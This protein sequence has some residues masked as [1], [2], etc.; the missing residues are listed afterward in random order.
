[1]K[2]AAFCIKRRVMIILAYIMVVIFGFVSFH[3]LALALMPNMEL[4][5][6]IVYTIYP[7]AG[8]EEVENLVTRPIEQ[9]LASLS[10]MDSLQSTSSENMSMVI[11]Q[12]TDDTDM[13]DAITNM[14]DKIDQM[15]TSLP[16]DCN[17]PT[18]IELDPDAMPVIQFG[19]T[20]SDLAQLQ[21]LG[22][23][24]ISPALERIDGVASV[25]IYGGYT[26]EIA[27]DMNT[28][29]MRGYNLSISYISQMLS[30]ENVAIPAG[31]IQNGTQKLTVRT[32]GEYANV[33]DIANTIIPLPTGGTIRLS[34]IAQVYQTHAD[35][36]SI[37]KMDGEQCVTMSVN[38]RSGVNTAAVAEEAI[39]V[40]AELKASNPQIEY[41][42]VLDQSDYINK[43]V[44]QVISNIVVGVILAAIVLLVF[45]RNIGATVVIALAMPICILTTFLMMRSL[46]LTMNMMSLG[47]MALG[48]GMIVDNSIVVLE[49]IYRFRDEGHSRYES[50]I[51]GTGEV[52]MSVVASTLTTIAVFL[53]IAL[54]GGMAGMMFK[55]FSL[56]IVSLLLSSLI[57]SLTLVPLL[58]Y[59]LLDRGQRMPKLRAKQVKNA[60]KPKHENP[61]SLFYRGILNWSIHHRFIFCIVSTALLVVFVIGIAGA[62]VELIP[63]SDQ[64]QVS[65]TINMPIGS[66]VDDSSEYSDRVVKIAQDTIPE[67]KNLY[68][69][70]E[71]ES[72]TV[73]INLVDLADRERS[74]DEIGNQLR[75][76]LEGIAGAD[77][78]VSSEG[79]MGMGSMTGDAISVTISGNDF[80]VLGGIAADLEA[81]FS[82]IPG[83]VETDSTAQDNVPQIKI[84][85]NRENAANLG[86]TA[87]AIGQVVRSQIDGSTASTLKIDGEEY[88]IVVRG[89]TQS[90][91][92]IEA[93][94]NIPIPLNSGGSV[95]LNLVANVTTELAPQSISREDQE[96]VIS[97]TGTAEDNADINA[98]TL[99]VNE[100][101]EHYQM[102]EGY[103][104]DLGGQSEDI[105]ESFTTL[106]KA[107]LVALALVYF[108]LASQFDSFIMPVIIMLILPFG[109]LG[110]LFGLPLF[111]FRISMVAFIGVIVLAGTVVNASIILVDYI[112]TRRQ[113]GEDK[114]TAI[115]NACPLRVRPVMMTALT[116]ILGLLPMALSNAEGSETMKPMAVVMIA[117]MII[118]TLTT[119]LVTPV[120]YSIIDSLTSRF[121][122]N[123]GQ[124]Q[125]PTD[126]KDEME[127]MN[128]PGID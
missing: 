10:G 97:V 27:I 86:L 15:R 69:S 2:A 122:R 117:G 4:P 11:I 92:S 32:T 63:A 68:Y 36:D 103:N 72:S 80:A 60:R 101:L 56:T 55:E 62:G 20:G 19:L 106:L 70:A 25:D 104:Y 38:K 81:E 87:A 7:G 14:R 61:L 23:D 46:D 108:I 34:E 33:N 26:T 107:L 22:E 112:K 115:L 67:I 41:V 105:V 16:D 51:Y 29:R 75:R 52:T 64:G 78:S 58:C 6:S 74:A 8:P 13:D 109:L 84:T 123:V 83:V 45:L 126:I 98:I 91:K 47:G 43:S 21:R 50:C 96:R 48:V 28:E 49:N 5:I 94:K 113:K 1:M 30:A 93:I 9:N 24:T 44:D 79:S 31:S 82:T 76:D 57:I 127:A 128:T 114:N 125:I 39:A 17:D 66:Q 35:I 110:G 54:S 99:A 95:P 73:S 121:H 120:Y 53:P 119:L 90:S 116:T 111:G 77:I 40:L 71:S 88:D 100:I 59:V 102:P 65:V 124:K 18:V 37:V 42:V 118:A 89:D 85:L 12:F 3:G